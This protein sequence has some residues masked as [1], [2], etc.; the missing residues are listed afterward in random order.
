VCPLG[1]SF[2]GLSSN[3]KKNLLD[4]IYYLT[5]FANFSYSDLMSMPSFE[6]RFFMDK[7]IEE[8]EKKD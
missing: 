7:L 5:K 4:E 3:H 1:L 2:F 8:Y 6:R